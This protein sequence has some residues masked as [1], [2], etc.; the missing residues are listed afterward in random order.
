MSR[1]HDV[2]AMT[3]RRYRLPA[4]RNMLKD[5]GFVVI[6]STYFNSISFVPALILAYYDYVVKT[7]TKSVV[8]EE[9][10]KELMMQH[11]LITR[12]LSASMYLER[13]IIMISGKM[14]FG[15]TLLCIAQKR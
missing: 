6:S 10:V 7:K 13:K 15:V 12:I 3:I 1:K 9:E 2:Q 14:P 4:F 8:K 11:S 5:A